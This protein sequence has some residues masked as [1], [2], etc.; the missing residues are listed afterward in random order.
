MRAD[1]SI[2]RYRIRDLNDVRG[3]AYAAIRTVRTTTTAPST[4]LKLYE[5]DVAALASPYDAQRCR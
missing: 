3:G 2:D 4:R 1:F 5:S